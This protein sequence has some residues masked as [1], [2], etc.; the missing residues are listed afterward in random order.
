MMHI[1]DKRVFQFENKKY[2]R[3]STADTLIRSDRLKTEPIKA[4]KKKKF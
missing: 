1:V 4:R 2:P 3:L